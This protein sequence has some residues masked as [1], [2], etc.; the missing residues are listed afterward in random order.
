M[1]ADAIIDRAR[2][3]GRVFL[4]EIESKHLLGSAGFCTNDVRLVTSRDEAAL[5]GEQ[6]G[7][8]VVLKIISNE[9]FHKSDVGGV[10]L[11]LENSD[12]VVKAYNDILATVKS[13]Q[14]D[15]VIEGISIQRMA[16]PGVEVILGMFKDQQF[17]PVIM[18]GI[19]GELV[20]I[21]KDVSFGIVPIPRRHAY[22]MIT[23]IKGYP[24]LEGYRGREPVN[25]QM[26]EEM[27]LKLSD[28]AEQNPLIKE[29]DLNP[30]IAYNKDAVIVD[31]R[32]ILEAS[33]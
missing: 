3:T 10:K 25:I 26:L 4:N 27:L 29:I 32:I 16:R 28:F 19:G 5:L 30:V 8:P 31:A 13:K 7:Y 1:L 9:I 33:S 24:L 18:F 21:Y 20:E 6:L 22:Q 17:G 2:N 23:E 11:N 12:Q 14:P 15:A